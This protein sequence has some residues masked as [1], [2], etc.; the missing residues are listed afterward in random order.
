MLVMRNKILLLCLVAVLAI[1]STLGSAR[2]E[3]SHDPNAPV[4]IQYDST[5]DF[6]L[7]G[8]HAGEFAYFAFDYPGGGRVMTVQLD[9]A[10]GDPAAQLGLGFHIYGFN[11]YL[12][13][14]GRRSEEKVDRKVLRWAD[15]NPC[16]WLV[17]VYNYL[18][19]VPVGFHL[20]ITGLPEPTPTPHVVM[21]PAEAA[22]F[23][24]AQDHLIG[25]HAGNF[26]YYRIDSA[27]DGSQV[28]LNLYYSPDNQWV[29]N[30]FGMNVYAPTDGLLVAQGGHEVRFRR[31]I[32]GTYLVQ[33]YNYLPG[34]L[35]HFSLERR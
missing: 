5:F 19:G 1:A 27:A 31:D 15:D 11:G 30:A 23:T 18:P 8:N 26:K 12:I 13:G 29:S 16:R 33:V 7:L 14:S 34:A 32:A 20:E 28:V 35:V 17:Q 3:I 24:L 6:S 21:Q 9:M 10:P 4:L 22:S 25:D 2:A